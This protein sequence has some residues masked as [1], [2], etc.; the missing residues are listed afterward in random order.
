[1]TL[2]GPVIE[3]GVVG[4]GQQAGL[5]GRQFDPYAMY[6]DPTK[7]FRVPGFELPA[8]VTLGRLRSRIDLRTAIATRQSLG[9]A[10]F[11]SYYGKAM[12]LVE[13]G[14]AERAFRL[15]EEPETLR[16]QYGMTRFGQACLLARR[17][18]EAGTRF[19]Q[20]SWPAASDSEPTTNADG[21][22]DTHR[23]NFPMLRDWRCPVFDRTVSTL[24]TD[25]AARGLLD[26]TVV[27]AIGEF[28]R[29]PKIGQPTTDNVGPGGRDHWPECYTCLMA[30]GGIRGGQVYG[31]SDRIGAF[32]ETAPV[33][34]YDLISTVYWSL[35]IDPATEYHDT[36]NRP[37]RLVAHGSP[38]MG[39]F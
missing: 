11:E 3:S 33:H 39:L 27:W 9:P 20:V 38:V 13:S 24:L 23:N 17:L 2:S 26:E 14:Q 21:S 8:D 7:P 22:W 28:G 6:N 16:Q 5:F 32:P 19:V 12:A 25:L 35:G 30:G 34:P 29:S 1:V 15:N 18:I 10:D 4:V 36:L 31:E 37:R